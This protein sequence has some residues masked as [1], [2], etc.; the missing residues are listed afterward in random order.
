MQVWNLDSQSIIV[1]VHEWLCKAEILYIQL[2][3]ATIILGLTLTE[4]SV[5]RSWSNAI[6]IQE[7]DF[8]IAVLAVCDRTKIAQV[9]GHSGTSKIGYNKQLEYEYNRYVD[10]IL[11]KSY[12]YNGC[13]PGQLRL[14][15]FSEIWYLKYQALRLS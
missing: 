11:N 8:S 4:L 5:V 7:T 6:V 9:F 2:H 10:D 3:F 13:T 1:E 14:K 12:E 15:R